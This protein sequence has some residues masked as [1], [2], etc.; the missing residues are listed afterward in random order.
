MS[1]IEVYSLDKGANAK[2]KE[3]SA[4]FTKRVLRDSRRVLG[5]FGATPP[6]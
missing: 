1:C 5:D 2:V 4:E 3:A 6:P